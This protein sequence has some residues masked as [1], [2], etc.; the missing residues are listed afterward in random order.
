MKLPSVF[1]NNIEKNIDNN[2]SYYHGDSHKDEYKDL[3]ELKDMFDSKGFAN[4]IAVKLVMK[5]DRIVDDKLVLCK[6]NYF[7]NLNNDR[8]YFDSIKSYEIKK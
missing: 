8:I 4:R 7:V 5:D 2:R 3:K 1:A 6:D